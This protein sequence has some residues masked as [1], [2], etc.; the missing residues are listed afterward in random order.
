MPKTFKTVFTAFGLLALPIAVSSARGQDTKS[1]YP[2]MAPLEQYLMQRDAEIALARSA[3]AQPLAGNAEIMV[4]GRHGYETAIHG[5]NGFVCMVQRSW[6]AGF[7]DPEFW[8]PKQRSPICFNP[9]AARSYLP[10]LIKKTGLALSGCSKAQ[11]IGLV[12]TAVAKKELPGMEPGAMGYM[13]SKQGYL[14]DRDG[15]WHPHLM[16][17][18]PPTEPGAWGAGLPE[19]PLFGSQ[20]DL[21]RVTVFFIPVRKWSDGTADSAEH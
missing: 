21:V 11:M 3:A 4:L 18:L 17:F 7:D 15:H 5:K 12:S 9:A 6:A 8:N 20:D 1:A 13:L 10:L 2:Q 14:N 19:S 16:F